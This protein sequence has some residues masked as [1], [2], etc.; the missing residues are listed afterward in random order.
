MPGREVGETVRCRLVGHRV[1]VPQ[2]L[3]GN[4][5]GRLGPLQ[6]GER[7]LLRDQQRRGEVVDL[8]PLFEELRVVLRHR[9]AEHHVAEGLQ[10]QRSGVVLAGVGLR[11]V[12]DPVRQIGDGSG[13]FRQ[14]RGVHQ[15]ESQMGG[16]SVDHGPGDRPAV[17]FGRG[18]Q[19]GRDG[20]DLAEVIALPAH[21]IAQVGIRAAGLL[22]SGGTLGLNPGHRAVQTDQ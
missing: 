20:F 5:L 22:R 17:V 4:V 19:V 21:P 3:D 16:Q 18:E 8:H 11:Q 13:G 2:V 1:G 15:P 6:Q 14:I 7:A 10:G 9:M 12:D